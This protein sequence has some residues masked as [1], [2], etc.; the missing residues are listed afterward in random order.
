MSA[1][2]RC[3]FCLK[4]PALTGR[5]GKVTTISR[6]PVCRGELVVSRTRGA[7][8]RYEPTEAVGEPSGRRARG[9]LAVAGL[10]TALTAAGVVASLV[11][12]SDP[13]QPPPATSTA[14]ARTDD[15]VRPAA[16]ASAPE[17]M[18]APRA[19][20][21]EPVAVAVTPKPAV[22]PTPS[23]PP[24]RTRSTVVQAPAAEPAPPAAPAAPVAVPSRWARPYGDEELVGLLAK[25]P[26][27]S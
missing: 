22:R 9:V 17:L 24:T 2:D 27:V 18:P 12:R 8:Y 3:A 11:H 5:P 4:L 19:V 7:T 13:A 20:R 23:R 15:L 25:V 6:C 16:V 14:E 10:V 26:E 1:D 21:E